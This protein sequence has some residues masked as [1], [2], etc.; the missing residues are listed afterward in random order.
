MS[1]YIRV[2]CPQCDSEEIVPK[3]GNIFECRDCGYVDEEYIF[4]DVVVDE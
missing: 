4:E 3:Y 2:C 1:E